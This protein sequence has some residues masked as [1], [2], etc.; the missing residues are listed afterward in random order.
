MIRQLFGRTVLVTDS[1]ITST[2]ADFS[3]LN[4]SKCYCPTKSLAYAPYFRHGRSISPFRKNDTTRGAERDRLR[5]FRLV[6]RLSLKV[7]HAVTHNLRRA[8]TLSRASSVCSRCNQ[9]SPIPQFVSS[10]PGTELP[11]CDIMGPA[12][13]GSGLRTSPKVLAQ[14]RS[15]S[16]I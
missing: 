1:T 2:T 13:N 9:Y 6:L 4:L 16:S 12:R 11:L 5:I 14:T 10:R 15:R 7:K 3:H 8:L